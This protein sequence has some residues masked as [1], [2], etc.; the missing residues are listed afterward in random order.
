[1]PKSSTILI[2]KMQRLEDLP[3][4]ERQVVRKFLFG[5]I[6]GLNEQHEKRWRRFWS[7]I[8]RAEVGEVFDI[9]IN[10]ARSGQFHRRH[11]AIEQML[12]DRQ[13][14]W[15]RIEA[16]RLWLK[17]GAMWGEYTLLESGRMKFVP[18]STSY[19]KCSDDEMREV[20]EAM[21]AFLRTP[22]AQRRLWPHLS[23]DARHEM[24]EAIVE[25]PE[26][27]QP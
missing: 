7:R 17:T 24:L 21:V 11:M 16:M 20:H 14:R 23:T 26:Q 27:D 8:Q 15:A 3:E 18:K 12:F 4:S 13:E 10:V 5:G 19:E 9:Q 25:P 22:L 2:A 6:Q 1:M